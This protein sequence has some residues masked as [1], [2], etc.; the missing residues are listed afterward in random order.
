M[1]DI[2]NNLILLLGSR[3]F[4]PHY[5]LTSSIVDIL[6]ITNTTLQL[7]LF[8][9]GGMALITPVSSPCVALIRLMRSSN[10]EKNPAPI[11]GYL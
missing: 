9:H 2:V 7:L 5:I 1:P 10:V 8:L 11:R 6:F 4:V 3:Y